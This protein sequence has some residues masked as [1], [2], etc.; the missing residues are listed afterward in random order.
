MSQMVSTYRISINAKPEDVYAYVADIT[1]HGEWSENVKVE[2]VSDGPIGVDSTYR[3]TGRMMRK[4]F[5][6]DIRVTV[7]E[8]STHLS[9]IAGDGK[10]EFLQ[11]FTFSSSDEGTLLERRVSF[12]MN[13]LMG[14]LLKVMI[15]PLVSNPSMNRSLNNLKAKLERAA[16]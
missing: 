4:E 11:E 8:P 3:S 13:P 14:L 6:N 5:Q 10:N 1:R 2:A 15:G 9:F 7:Y 12:E 16:P